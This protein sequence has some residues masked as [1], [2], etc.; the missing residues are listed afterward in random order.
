MLYWRFTGNP[1]DYLPAVMTSVGRYGV[2]N[3]SP[4]VYAF[5]RENIAITGKGMLSPEMDTWK[6]WFARPEA[7]MEH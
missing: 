2:Y 7:H 1:S 4:L 3:Y 6:S 5:E